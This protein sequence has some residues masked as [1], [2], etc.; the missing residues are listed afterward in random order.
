M[1]NPGEVN[2]RIGRIYQQVFIGALE[3]TI[4]PFEAQFYVDTDPL[5]TSFAGRDGNNYSFDFCGTYNHPVVRKE[6]FGECKG[7][8]TRA[9]LL[10]DF[11]LFLARAYVTSVDNRRHADDYFWFITNV[12]FA[13]QEGTGVRTF[14]FVKTT[15]ET[16]A[17]PEMDAVLGKGKIDD[18]FV[19]RLVGNLGVFILTDSFL[20][21]TEISYKIKPG[22]TVWDILK[23]LHGTNAQYHFAAFAKEIAATNRLKSPDHIIKNKRIRLRWRGLKNP[24]PQDMP[25][26]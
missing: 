22:D 24:S 3:A 16:R 15:L 13:C 6:V 20:Q 1:P 4:R 19:Q 11:R 12:P 14:R 26:Y 23:N 25:A 7:Y 18:A 10:P 8:T 17:T 2:Q 21:S 9:G 5:K